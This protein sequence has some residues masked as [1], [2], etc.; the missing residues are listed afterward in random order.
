MRRE[1]ASAKFRSPGN[2][3]K[4][5]CRHEPDAAGFD[6]GREQRL[7]S[8]SSV[9]SKQSALRRSKRDVRLGIQVG[10]PWFEGS[11]AAFTTGVRR[12][13]LAGAASLYAARTLG[14]EDLWSAQQQLPLANEDGYRLWLRYVPIPGASAYRRSLGQLLIEGSSPTATVIRREMSA[15]LS[16][17]LGATLPDASDGLRDGAIVVGT[18]DNSPAIKGLGWQGEL[19]KMGAEGYVIRPARVGSRSVIAIASA[20]EVG[21]LYG[22]FHF[23]RLLQIDA[24][25]DKLDKLN[26]AERPRVQLRLLNHWDNLD[27][28]IERGYAG[29]SIWQW[30]ELP[31][32]ISP[33]YIDYARANA[34][35][36]INGS[37]VNSVNADVRVL[38][39]EYLAKVAALAEAWRPYGVRMY[40]SANVAAPL[41]LGKLTTADPLDPGVASWWKQKVDE[42]YKI[43][44]DFGGF[45]VKANSEGQPG[46]KDYGRTHAEGAN[47]LADALAPHGGSVVWRAFIYDE[48]VDPDRAKRAYIEFTKLDGQ[49]RPNALLQVKNG[50]IDFMP[51]E[52]FHPLVRRAREDPGARR[53]PGDA[54]ISGAGEAP[55]VPRNDVAGVPRGRYVRQRQGI[56]GRQSD[57]RR[58]PPVSRD[59]RGVGGEPRPRPRTGA[60]I[61]SRSPTGMRPAGWRGTPA[62]LPGRSPR[63]GRA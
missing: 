14:A 17:M 26:I 24:S 22:A 60:G 20:G 30:S 45:T 29:R 53:D 62:C 41:R 7:G 28:T 39:P 59:R 52:P 6:T 48:D 40:L 3:S 35:I 32:T 8:C 58:D 36:G 47:V 4:P 42:I 10:L 12:A 34:S 11:H 51:R 49:F 55:G 1:P 16:S 63:S 46:P 44:P 2:A 21:S 15:A 43:I 57:R 37:V 33:R 5:C 38:S 56:D 25:L 19:A 23:L 54:G 9:R 18:P 27:G 61:T 13:G 31:G 50:A